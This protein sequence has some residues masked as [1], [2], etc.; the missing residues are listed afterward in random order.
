MED[1]MNKEQNLEMIKELSEAKGPSGFEDEAAAAIKRWGEALFPG[2]GQWRED[3]M[4]NLYVQPRPGAGKPLVMLDAHSDEVGFMVRAIRPNGTLDF[5]SLGGWSPSSV[6]AHRVRVRNKEGQWIPGLVASKPPHYSSEAERKAAPDLAAMVIDLGA[7]SAQEVVDEFKV[8]IAAPV[9]PEAAFEYQ[10]E[11]DLLCGKA[12]DC[13]LGCAAELAAL[14]ELSAEIDELPVALAGS[15][16]AQEEVGCRGASVTALEI[17]P[18]IA[19]CFEGCPEDDTVVESYAVQTALKKG[20]MLRH[21]DQRMITNPRFQRF[22]LDTAQKAG[23]PVQ[24]AVRTGG[25]TNGGA[26][27][28][29]GKAIPVIVIGVPI[30]YIHTHYGF[31]A[32]TDFEQSVR[33]ACALIRGLSASVINGF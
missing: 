16:A 13:R 32:Y 5:V 30:R 14:K 26:I 12:F 29:A 24:E 22:A 11:H 7:S 21:I 2:L 20:P 25:A 19:I 23:I 15:F 31:A 1:G 33:L 28:L 17:Q 3:R 27:H 9:V 8:G 18:D 10:S 4:R 6:P